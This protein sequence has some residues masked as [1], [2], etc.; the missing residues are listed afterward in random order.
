VFQASF[1]AKNRYFQSSFTFD[2]SSIVINNM[3]TYLS[4]FCLILFNSISNGEAGR[5]R[6]Q[7]NLLEF[8]VCP[9]NHPY[10]TN[11]GQ[12]C[13]SGDPEIDCEESVYCQALKCEDAT[14]TCP[15]SFITIA[16]MDPEYDNI[17]EKIENIYEA[18]RPIYQKNGK[19][20]WWHQLY[21]HWW[22]GPCEN[23]GTNTGFAYIEGDE[24][25]PVSFTNT[26]VWRRGGSDEVIPGVNF[27]N[28]KYANFS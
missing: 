10:E 2:T 22:T 21:R 25:C 3:L 27:I 17:Y 19:C 16:N 13:C 4:L 28:V 20:I 18:N 12:I 8:A 23:V 1:H 5:I 9:T 26:I 15:F 24:K 7:E 11:N 14:S 6:R